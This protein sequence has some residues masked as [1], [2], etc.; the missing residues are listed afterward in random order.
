MLFFHRL[1]KLTMLFPMRVSVKLPTMINSLWK[2]GLMAVL[3]P[4]DAIAYSAKILKQQ[5]DVFINFEEVEEEI[6]P[7]KAE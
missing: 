3:N 7:E 1:K 2:Y 5:L 6:I 4:E